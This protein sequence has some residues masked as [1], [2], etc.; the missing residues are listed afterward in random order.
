VTLSNLYSRR[1][2]KHGKKKNKTLHYK[3]IYVNQT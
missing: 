2:Q 3:T 1:A